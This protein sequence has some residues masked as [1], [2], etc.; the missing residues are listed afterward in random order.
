MSRDDF[1]QHVDDLDLPGEPM[2]QPARCDGNHGIPRCAD[3]GCW[4]DENSEG[5]A[6]PAGSVD[7][8]S[9][10]IAVDGVGLHIFNDEF[11]RC[12]VWL[13]TDM[14]Q[15]FDGV[16]IGS[17]ATRDAAVADAVLTLQACVDRLQ[18]KP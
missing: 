15:D 16:W 4:Q 2:T 17:G 10:H 5:G 8:I 9:Q 12:D 7:E 14:V 11:E 13:T 1:G 18:V 6:E 3:P